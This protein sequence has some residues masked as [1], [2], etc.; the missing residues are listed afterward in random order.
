MTS[1]EVRTLYG[2]TDYTRESQFMR[3]VDKTLLDGDAVYEKKPGTSGAFR[4]G[5]ASN[6]PFKPFDQLRY[7]RLQTKQK[8][9]EM[10]DS[11]NEDF[12]VGDRVSHP[13]FGEGEVLEVGKGII[14]VK[15]ADDTKKLA[16]GYAAIKKI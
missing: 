2:K 11:A 13:K 4:D 15:F 1:A 14:R 16:L 12:A 6:T 10:L 5:A 3:E 7:A 8:A 9:Q